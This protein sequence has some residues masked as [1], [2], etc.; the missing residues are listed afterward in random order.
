MVDSAESTIIVS[1]FILLKIV[2]MY[3]YCKDNATAKA[4]DCVGD[5]HRP[6]YIRAVQQSLHHKCSCSNGHHQE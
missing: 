3:L 1:L 6:N 2:V 5:E 4:R